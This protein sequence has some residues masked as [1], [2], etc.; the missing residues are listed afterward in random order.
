ML[1]PVVRETS[2][3]SAHP[4]RITRTELVGVTRSMDGTEAGADL[5]GDR[6][7]RLPTV[8]RSTVLRP[9]LRSRLHSIDGGALRDAA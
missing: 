3:L 7:L 4:A 9:G 5:A 1:T 2:R 8:Q 6:V